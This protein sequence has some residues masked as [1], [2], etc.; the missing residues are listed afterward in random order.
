VLSARL[1][2]WHPRH[3][4]L[5]PPV[6]VDLL[7][8]AR[9]V[10]SGVPAL[11]DHRLGTLERRLLAIERVGDVSGAE[12]AHILQRALVAP[13]DPWAR[14]ARGRVLA[15][16]RADVLTPLLLV[17][18]LA[19]IVRAPSDRTE[20]LGAARQ[21]EAIG[22]PAEA[23]ARLEA[24][25]PHARPVDRT[26]IAV[27]LAAAELRR[28]SGDHFGA[29]TLWAR[30]CAWDPGHVEAHERLAKHLEHRRHD[31]AAALA[32]ARASHAPCA[33]RLDRLAR[34]AAARPIP[35]VDAALARTCETGAAQAM[36]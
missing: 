13:S 10:L 34:K 27:A 26:A 12:V 17:A 18:R 28:R 20:A 29:A 16:N 23:L 4:S 30:V 7:A 21:L 15:H 19:A 25:L 33:R 14:A 32:V 35:A 24:I 3:A 36:V 31:P 8:I 22:R 2:R 9:R 6:H 11:A 1:V 5:R